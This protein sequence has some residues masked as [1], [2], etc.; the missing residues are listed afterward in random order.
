MTYFIDKVL[1]RTLRKI[2]Q[3]AEST[4]IRAPQKRVVFMHIP[5]C[6][7]TTIVMAAK[8]YFGSQRSG[9]VVLLDDFLP[10]EK[11][12]ELIARAKD[13]NFVSGHFGFETLEELRGDAYVFTILRDPYERLRSMYGFMTALKRNNP[14]PEHL[15][16]ATIDEFFLSKDDVVLQWN[17]N[18]IA[19]MLAQ[20]CDL[21][22]LRFHDNDA[23]A[24]SAIKNLESF[25]YIGFL[26]TLDQDLSSIARAARIRV[27][28]DPVPKNTTKSHLGNSKRQEAVE[29]FDAQVRD[30]VSSFVDA[31][32]RVYSAAQR[33]R[34]HART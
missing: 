33:F 22:K 17:N 8:S 16:H 10:S 13:A 19:R 21:R 12:R 20:T 28:E 34:H 23:L 6:A 11:R 9:R 25:D 14:L 15:R 26:D 27:F 32:E 31:D 4:G 5:K 18:L 2:H 3:L 29:P 30:M 7:G 24:A 1:Y